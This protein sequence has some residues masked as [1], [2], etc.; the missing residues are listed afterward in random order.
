[1]SFNGP[2]VVKIT[3][4]SNV[5]AHSEESNRLTQVKRQERRRITHH[6][7]WVTWSGRK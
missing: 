3:L 6:E 7:L 4:S 2:Q 1:M 5:N